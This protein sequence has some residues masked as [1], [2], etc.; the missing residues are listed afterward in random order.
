MEYFDEAHINEYLSHC[1]YEKRL[2]EKTL[3]AYGCDLRQ[4]QAWAEAQ[5]PTEPMGRDGI[6]AYL[7]H[8]NARYAPATT[9]RK[10][11][12]LNAYFSYLVD[13][14][15][16]SA[17]P[18]EGLRLNIRAPKRLPRTICMMELEALYRWHDAGEGSAP[19][20]S[21]RDR[22][23][24]ELLIAT[25]VRVSELCA[26]DVEDCDLRMRVMRI[27]GKG[28]KE[29]MVQLES[30]PA[31][32]ALKEYLDESAILRQSSIYHS[33]ALFLNRYGNR[34]SDQ[35]VRSIVAA[36]A[37]SAGISSRITPHMFRHTFATLLLESDVD[38]RF[39]QSLL[40]HSSIKTTE[41]YTHVAA[42]KQRD[43]LRRHN[44]RKRIMV[45]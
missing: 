38:I 18:F 19:C 8:A 11:A 39:I 22:A 6:R 36:R 37:K 43:V 4:I 45:E 28:A 16:L 29:R 32:E 3:R 34:L 17:N 44:P 24:L 27:K 20:P 15:M 21:S 25:G 30:E 42:A 13:C 14:G 5:C 35:A 41:I 31:L 7:A 9:K 40:G 12:S 26:L 33:R 2:S 1:R 23:V 10:L